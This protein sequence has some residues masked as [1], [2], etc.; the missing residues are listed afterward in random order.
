MRVIYII[1]LLLIPVEIMATHSGGN[2]DVH[3]NWF[4]IDTESPPVGWYIINFVIFFGGLIYLLRN[5]LNQFFVARY[6]TMKRQMDESIKLRDEALAKLKEIEDKINRISYYQ[7]AI[8]E[9]YIDMAKKEKEDILNH[10]RRTAQSLINAAEQTILF[11][12]AELKKELIKQILKSATEKSLSII[13]SKYSPERD[14][15]IVEE[16]VNSLGSV[17]RKHFGY[18]I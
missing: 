14:R 13:L 7:S 1:L 18:L 11:E 4:S 17:N 8:K 5:R 3:I 9:E 12:K 2:Q 16:F 6:E 10:A 15:E